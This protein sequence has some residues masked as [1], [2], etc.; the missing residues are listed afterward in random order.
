MAASILIWLVGNSNLAGWA[1]HKGDRSI[2]GGVRESNSL[3]FSLPILL[4]HTSPFCLMTIKDEWKGREDNSLRKEIE[5]S[6]GAKSIQP[7][8]PSTNL[9]LKMQFVNCKENRRLPADVCLGCCLQR[10]LT[11]A[12]FSYSG[13]TTKYYSCCSCSGETLGE[14]VMSFKIHFVCQ[15]NFYTSVD[16]FYL[17]VS[18]VEPAP[19]ITTLCC[20]LGHKGISRCA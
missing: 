12:T 1:G 18:C 14:G 7:C 10:T 15:D 17:A 9:C 13:N 3:S 19:L 16:I 4:Y 2:S 8:N 20:T 11:P 6:E 5:R